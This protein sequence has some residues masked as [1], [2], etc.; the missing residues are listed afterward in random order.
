[1]APDD[2]PFVDVERSV[3]LVKAGFIKKEEKEKFYRFDE[4]IREY[5]KADGSVIDPK[6]ADE[7]VGEEAVG[8]FT[9]T[10]F[11]KPMKRFRL[12]WEV[13]DMNIEQTYFWVIKQ[14]RDNLGF[15]RLEKLEDTL[16]AAENSAIFGMSQQRLG[17]QQDK[18]SAYL[19]TI[20]KMIKEL[21]QMVRELRVIDEKKEYYEGADRGEKSSEITLKGMF[22]DLVQGG[23][24]NPASVYGMARELE[25]TTLPDLFFDVPPLKT[26]EDIEKHVEALQFNK[27]VKEVLK[28]HLRQYMEWKKRT[29]EEIHTRRKFMLQYLRQHY[30]I[31]KMYMDWIKPYL[32]Y[33]RRL[34]MRR[35]HMESAEIISAFEGAVIDVEILAS[36]SMGSENPY[37]SCIL[38]TFHY[39]T[40][41][42]LKFQEEGYQR[43]PIHVGRMEMTVRSYVWK[44]EQIA[45]YHRFKQLED[46]ELLGDVTGGVKAAMEALGEE[47]VKYLEEAGE[48]MRKKAGALPAAPSKTM[49]ETLFGDFIGPRK[50]KTAKP[51]RPPQVDEDQEEEWKEKAKGHVGLNIWLVYNNFKKAHGIINW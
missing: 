41:P 42:Q 8:H 33:A 28:R 48:M 20:G 14:L 36:R 7:E 43:G 2:D 32:R 30:D 39:R 5:V 18:V 27:K 16:S 3:L 34:S 38:A 50:P 47:L 24:K 4:S 22:I 21:F 51:S 13:A 9:E 37:H 17:I 26:V 25:F 31:I 15:P 49:M 23:A 12:V 40:S 11:P 35:K 6:H 1:M 29:Y 19:A 10:G 45:Q 46:F 44:K